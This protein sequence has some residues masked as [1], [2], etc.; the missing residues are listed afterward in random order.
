MYYRVLDKIKKLQEVKGK[1]WNA[2]QPGTM[3][4]ENTPNYTSTNS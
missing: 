3:E 4:P 1:I 2:T